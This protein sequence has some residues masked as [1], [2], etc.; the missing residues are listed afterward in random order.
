MFEELLLTL[1]WLCI[2]NDIKDKKLLIERNPDSESLLEE[3]QELEKIKS[4][5]KVQRKK[6]KDERTGLGGE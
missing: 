2:C 4:I 6:F 1:D 5:L 3:L